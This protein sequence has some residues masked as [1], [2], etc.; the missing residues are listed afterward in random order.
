MARHLG[1]L[2][3]PPTSIRLMHPKDV[4]HLRLQGVEAGHAIAQRGF[5]A[6]SCG[7]QA[8]G[9]LAHKKRHPPRARYPCRRAATHDSTHEDSLRGTPRPHCRGNPLP[10]P[11]PPHKEAATAGPLQGP[12]YPASLSRHPCTFL[13]TAVVGMYDWLI[14]ES[15]ELVRVVRGGRHYRGALFLMSEVPL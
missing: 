7:T 9:Y 11:P 1:A 13:Q 15:L 14:G 3:L 2:H 10:P 12:R 4:L 6:T 8:Q 5:E